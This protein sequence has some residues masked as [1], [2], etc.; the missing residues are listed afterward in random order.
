MTIENQASG[1]H[2]KLVSNGNV[3]LYANNDGNV[4]IGTTSPSAKLHV[5]G[6]NI[7][8]HFH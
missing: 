7:S 2:I 6:G 1:G 3:N 8:L 4:G 5:S